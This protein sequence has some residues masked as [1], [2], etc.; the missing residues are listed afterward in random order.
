MTKPKEKHSQD[1]LEKR[2]LQ[3]EEEKIIKLKYKLKMEVH[4]FS[5]ESN[6]LFHEWSLE[7]GRINRAEEKKIILFKEQAKKWR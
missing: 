4:N 7:R 2:E 3:K 6:R 5:R 1:F